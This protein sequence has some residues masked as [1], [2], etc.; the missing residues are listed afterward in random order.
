MWVLAD[1]SAPLQDFDFK[2]EISKCQFQRFRTISGSI[3]LNG[4]NHRCGPGALISRGTFECGRKKD[5]ANSIRSRI[6]G[7]NPELIFQRHCS[8]SDD[9]QELAGNFGDGIESRPEFTAS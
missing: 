1:S 9:N 4:K 3:E 5:G 2:Y 6:P 7:A 8:V